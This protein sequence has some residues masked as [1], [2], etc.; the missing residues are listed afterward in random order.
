MPRI[1][2]DT[3]YLPVSYMY[4]FVQRSHSHVQL[5]CYCLFVLWLRAAVVVF[6]R[7]LGLLQYLLVSVTFHFMVLQFYERPMF[8]L[9]C[10]DCC[11]PAVVYRY[12]YR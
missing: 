11:D 4:H 10:C 7:L 5:L 9:L 1:G 6:G 2:A 8:E 3:V 12:M